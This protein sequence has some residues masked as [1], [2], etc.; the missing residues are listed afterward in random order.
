VKSEADRPVHIKTVVTLLEMI[1]DKATFQSG[2]DTRELWKVG[3]AIAVA[4]MGSLRGPEVLMLDLAGIRVHIEEERQGVM[5]DSSLDGGVGLDQRSP[6]FFPKCLR[7]W[8][9]R[10]G[11]RFVGR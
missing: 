11:L 2:Y 4:Q 7:P 10:E 8:L 9:L 6:K 1:K 5:P 3:A